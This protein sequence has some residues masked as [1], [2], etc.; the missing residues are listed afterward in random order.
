[1]PNF[2]Q[3]RS[4]YSEIKLADGHNTIITR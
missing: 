2:V 4:V 1:M 3:I